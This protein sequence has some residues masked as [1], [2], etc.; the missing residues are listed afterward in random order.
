MGLLNPLLLL[1]AGAAAVPLLLHLLQRHQGPRVVFPALRYLRRAEKESARRIRL[2]QILLMLLRIAAILL[3]A[4]AAARPFI[5]FGG[6]GH[7]PTAV[8]IVLDNSMS[9]G[10]VEGERRV[11]DELAARALEMLAEAGPDDRFWLLRAGEP[12][13]PAWIGDAAATALRVRETEPAAGAA[14][15]VTALRRATTILAAGAEGRAME[16]HLLT[17]LQATGF[18]ASAP[19][20]SAAPP[21][22]VWHPG[23]PAPENLAIADI[24]VGGGMQPIAGQR[25]TIAV[26][27]GGA[28]DATI[29]SADTVDVR[30]LLDGRLMAA[31]AARDGAA[32]LLTLPARPAGVMSG[33][34]EI[35]ADALRADD[36]RYFAAHVQPPP[37]VTLGGDASFIRDALDV[38]ADA[39]RVRVAG[40]IADIVIL[41]G[42]AGAARGNASLVILPPET[43]T[44]LAAV[45]RRLGDA[46]IPWTYGAPVSG[47]ARFAPEQ[48]DPLLRSLADA[49][50][51]LVYPLAAVTESPGDSVLVR[52]SDG[53][54]WA[55]RGERPNGGTYVLLGSPLSAE[56]S[57]VPTSAAMLPLLDRI[58]GAWSLAQALRTDASPGDEIALPSGATRVERPDG[59]HDSVN[60]NTSYRFGTEPGIYRVL[61]GDSAIAAHAVNAPP[62]ESV[63]E[64][65]SE[66]DLEERLPGWSLHVTTSD[67]AWR[68][69]I[70]RER[71]GRELWRPLLLALLLVLLAETIVAASGRTR[72]ADTPGADT[73]RADERT[74]TAPHAA[75][76]AVSESG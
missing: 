25:T 10:T 37:I 54:A 13:E 48:P 44:E 32:A 69:A 76:T 17:D 28:D 68:R 23:T 11:L 66:D 7:S 4:F 46:G 62:S 2:R 15:I 74:A 41:P 12:H 9:S 55:V 5:G 24:E 49:R 21:V 33:T 19:S 58:T 16:I 52:L 34:V 51:Q 27:I 38:L 43:P 1:L 64:R 29:T 22:V 6:A 73:A 30:L 31:A 71:L 20:D 72:R 70:F 45:N 26:T 67:G 18:A 75:S 42:A 56:A 3:L 36:R 47:E 60:G 61:S 63:L 53:S 50:I 57:T 65:L 35:D 39:G 40:G 14:D 59:T 8:V